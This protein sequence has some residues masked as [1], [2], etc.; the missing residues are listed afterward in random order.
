M[1]NRK[2]HH[3]QIKELRRLAQGFALP[4]SRNRELKS[5]VMAEIRFMPQVQPAAEPPAFAR[6]WWLRR[7]AFSTLVG[8]GVVGGTVFASAHA[9]PGDLLY[10]VKIA[11]EKVELSLAP[12]G[13]PKALIM[14]K[15]AEERLSELSGLKAEAPA[16][17]QPASPTDKERQQAEHEASVQVRG[18]VN[19]LT[20]VKQDLEDK[21]NTTAAASVNNVLTR[22]VE[23]AKS[24]DIELEGT[25]G[26]VP[27][28]QEKASPE[29]SEQENNQHPEGEV[30]GLRHK[31]TDPNPSPVRKGS[32]LEA[33]LPGLANPD[34]EPTSS[35]PVLPIGQVL[36]AST[37][38]PGGGGVY[39]T[40]TDAGTTTTTGPSLN[41]ENQQNETETENKKNSTEFQH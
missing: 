5:K 7:L 20:Q 18:A 1:F 37:T 28:D 38:S 25:V 9:L 17:T 19:S 22:L 15:Q 16:A 36:G 11:K 14:A 30:K 24:Q 21:G 2:N 10:P 4:E 12:K 35:A 26:A 3:S 33:V 27:R 40:S 29:K 32:G 31:P 39:A 8:V 6:G 23:K 13:E 34:I 41:R